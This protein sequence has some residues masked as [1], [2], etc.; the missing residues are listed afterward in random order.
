LLILIFSISI[1]IYGQNIVLPSQINGLELWLTG[2]SI[3][4]N[5]SAVDIC[6][7]IS[8]NGNHAIQINSNEMPI[9]SYQFLNNHD[10]LFFDGIDDCLNFNSINDIRTV[11]WV[12][13]ED[14]GA[15]PNFRSLLGYSASY[16]Y[17]F[18]RNENNLNIWGTYTSSSIKNGKTWLNSSMV[19][20][21]VTPIPSDFS[22]ISV[23]TTSNVRASNFS[24]DRSIVSRT[25][26][27][28]LAELIVF[29]DSLNEAERTTV[30]HY[31]RYKYFPSQYVNPVDLGTDIYIPYGFCP[32]TIDAGARFTNFLWNTGDITQTIQVTKSGEYS[33]IVT[34]IF[35]Y[36]SSD[37][38]MVY[39]PEP[40]QLPDT[41]I[42]YG[43]TINWN[44]NLQNPNYTFLWNNNSTDSLL[45]IY[46]AGD[47]YVK[48][49]DTLGC[50]FNSDTSHISIDNYPITTTLG[51]DTSLCAGQNLYLQQGATE[52]ASYLW[53]TGSVASYITVNGPSQYSVTCTNLIG[54][55]A[56]DTIDIQIHGFA[57]IVGFDYTNTC[58]NDNTIFSDT[59][60]TTDNSNIISRNWNFGN[61][62]TSNI[63]NP[64]LQYSD[65]GTF[66][67]SLTI[68]TDSACS[69]TIIKDVIINPLPIANFANT[70]LCERTDIYFTNTS[71]IPTG[72]IINSLWKYGN[73]DSSMSIS[74]I[75]NYDTAGYYN[76]QLIV[77]SNKNCKDTISENI[78]IKPI[79][80]TDFNFSATC[81]GKIVNFYNNTETLVYN[82]IYE[83]KWDFGDGNTSNNENVNYV[84]DINDTINDVT[85]YIKTIN[86]C[87]QSITKQIVM[88]N[89]PY[90]SIVNET[91]CEKNYYTLQD[92]VNELND[93]I[94]S[95]L[96]QV[97][98]N[99]YYEKNPEIYFNNSGTANLSLTVTSNNNCTN[100][101]TKILTIYEL[102]NSDFEINPPYGIINELTTLTPNEQ[103]ENKWTFG[104][105]EFSL[106]T[107]VSTSFSDSGTYAITH[108]STNHYNCVDSTKKD[109][110]VVFPKQDIAIT[111]I[112]T[113]I[114]NNKL[115]TSIG[116][117]NLGNLPVKKIELILT[118]ENKTPITEIWE[119]ELL[120]GSVLNYNFSSI[121]NLN[122]N[123]TPN[124]VCVTANLIDKYTDANLKNN[125][126]CTNEESDFQIFPIYPNPANNE[127]NIKLYIPET[128]ILSLELINN[129]GKTISKLYNQKTNKGM[130]VIKISL[131]QISLGS[132]SIKATYKDQDKTMRFI[133]E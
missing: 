26:Q 54:C 14:L 5:A 21:E 107:I 85:L 34:D 105:G 109:Y 127:I 115:Y 125:I 56:K 92:S 101:I 106:D 121:Y 100:N 1:F 97:D 74:P 29:S 112:N 42:C 82:P 78:E 69:N 72:S 8:G 40:Y 10:C 126:N 88:H 118:P 35:G 110:L 60:F 12:I 65:T 119:G 4:D 27:G 47:Y 111:S 24:R 120:F 19:D 11:F 76:L 68:T 52:T 108:Y 91:A 130:N 38:I 7:D 79:P 114:T 36:E 28:H 133:K 57:P 128:D 93:T 67:V 77:M 22:I 98:N 122:S 59:S 51:N 15:T 43:D 58:F 9:I 113:S 102:P 45:K 6:Y 32:T 70:Q 25:W 104:N 123:E 116:I 99:F 55:M 50:T 64:N 124:Y 30:E 73:G 39:Y 2:D 84:F 62:E 23:V 66:T 48:I 71:S 37:T 18:M 94:I 131:P 3:G 96:W 90:V 16:Y 46:N 103:N 129:I 81:K 61:G 63:Q 87:S 132:Y 89:I 17:D 20:G 31:L 80:K 117:L 53:N 44:I 33:V 95:Y 49:T 86:G 13:K 83:H 41:L 75:Y